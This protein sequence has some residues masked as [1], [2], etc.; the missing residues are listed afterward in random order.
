LFSLHFNIVFWGGETFVGEPPCGNAM[1][2]TI[3]K[4]EEMNANISY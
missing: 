2:A 4:K 3:E 1:R